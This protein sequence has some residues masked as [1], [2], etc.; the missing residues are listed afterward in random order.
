[1][2]MAVKQRECHPERIREGLDRLSRLVDQP[3]DLLIAALKDLVPEFRNQR[4]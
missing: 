4:P 1:M 2:I 3:P